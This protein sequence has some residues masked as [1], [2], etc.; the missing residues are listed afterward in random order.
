M[1]ESVQGLLLKA[2]SSK[3]HRPERVAGSIGTNSA[4]RTSMSEACERGEH[5]RQRKDETHPMQSGT[6]SSCQPFCL[7]LG[8]AD[9]IAV[10]VACELCSS[11]SQSQE[12]EARTHVSW[13]SMSEPGPV[14]GL[15]ACVL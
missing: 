12:A 7:K 6:A 4:S 3:S 8:T 14:R 2:G 5:H 11:S 13:P 9:C 1:S 10:N 15:F